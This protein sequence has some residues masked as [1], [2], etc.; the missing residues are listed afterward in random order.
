MSD[1]AAS[2]T[3]PPSSVAL[4][5][6][7]QA[8]PVY[9]FKD[10]TTLSNW[11]IAVIALGVVIAAVSIFSNWLQLQF[12]WDVEG[13]AYDQAAIAAPAEQNDSRQQI[14][15]IPFFAAI[16]ATIVLF[17]FWIPR[18]ARNARALGAKGMRISPG[19]AV[20]WYFIPFANLF[21]PYRA[22]KEIWKASKVPTAWEA[23]PRGAI[24]PWWWGLFLIS[25]MLGNAEFRLSLSAETMQQLILSTQVSIASDIAHIVASLAA[26]TLVRQIQNMQT[27]ARAATS[28]A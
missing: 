17:C 3:P 27:V 9:V 12:L 26:L 15:A 16:F 23:V 6:P 21:M 14:V 20:G 4:P 18:V 8:E 25:N 13:G 19:W 24:L 1:A 5:S 10:P 11:L 7:D 2:E 28:E 22:M